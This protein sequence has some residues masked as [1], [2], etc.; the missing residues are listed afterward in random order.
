[1]NALVR[2]FLQGLAAIMPVFLTAYLVI[3]LLI[4]LEGGIH[5][6]LMIVLPDKLYIPGMGIVLSFFAVIAVGYLIQLP[7]LNIP[8]RLGEA[9][10]KRL[11]LVKSLY[12]AIQDIADFLA[13]MRDSDDGKGTPVLVELAPGTRVIGFVTQSTPDL[14]NDDEHSLVY[15]PMSYQVG[16]YTALVRKSQLQPLDMSA[17]DCMRFV[18]TAG[19]NTSGAI[20]KD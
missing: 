10:L 13:S 17:E 5:N 2:M 20:S 15:M 7:V 8:V 1:M 19:L 14:A 11:P 18:L 3:A 12:K 4:W 16:G 9:I 6:V